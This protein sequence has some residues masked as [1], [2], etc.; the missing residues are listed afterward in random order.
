MLNGWVETMKKV[1]AQIRH[2]QKTGAIQTKG[3]ELKGTLKFSIK[4]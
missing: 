1:D 2:L 4:E 3:K